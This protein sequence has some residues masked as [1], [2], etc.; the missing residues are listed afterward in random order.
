MRTSQCH[1]ET[2]YCAALFWMLMSTTF[3]LFWLLLLSLHWFGF[4]CQWWEWARSLYH[5]I[6]ASLLWVE[7][8][9]QTNQ[10][11]GAQVC[12]KDTELKEINNSPTDYL[13]TEASH[14]SHTL[15]WLNIT[16][17]FLTN[18]PLFL[19]NAGYPFNLEWIWGCHE[20][21]QVFPA[22]WLVSDCM[23]LHH[24]IWLEAEDQSSC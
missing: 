1:A 3:F 9:Y 14:S 10:L 15:A 2:I 18:S 11:L 8:S 20:T 7:K 5:L 17:H 21:C 13:P 4:L 22:P 23:D 19:C 6:L 12:A 24:I 16:S